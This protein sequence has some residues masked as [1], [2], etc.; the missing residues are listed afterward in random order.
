MLGSN[1]Y[2]F[3]SDGG[4]VEEVVAADQL[5]SY[6]GDPPESK[7]VD[8]EGGSTEAPAGALPVSQDTGATPKRT[9]GET[10]EGA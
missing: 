9:R 7:E 2:R 4:Y 6:H 3:V 8:A 1:T 10:A 5:K